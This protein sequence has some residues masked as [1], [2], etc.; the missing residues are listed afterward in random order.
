LTPPGG[1]SPARSSWER[2]TAWERE[3]REQVFEVERFLA[4]SIAS[5]KNARLVSIAPQLGVRAGRRIHGRTTLTE[6]EVIGGNKSPLGVARGCW[7]MERWGNGLRPE[8][9]FLKEGDFYEIP[10]DCLR[11]AQVANLLAAGRCFAAAPAAMS[12]ARVI[13]TALGTGWAAG[14]LAAFQAL[15]KPVDEAIQRLRKEFL[16]SA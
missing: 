5:C 10:A 4:G 8:M 6:A 7:P 13:G 12:S 14:T 16:S 2:V 3:A 15:G 1:Q 11:V 9:T